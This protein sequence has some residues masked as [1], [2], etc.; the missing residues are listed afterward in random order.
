MEPDASPRE[1]KDL[2]DE[3][4]PPVAQEEHLNLPGAEGSLSEHE[5][6]QAFNSVQKVQNNEPPVNSSVFA[7]ALANK[8]Q[9]SESKGLQ[10]NAQTSSEPAVSI[11]RQESG[12][13]SDDES[14]SADDDG[15]APT[16]L[17]KPD[18][19]EVVSEEVA[20]YRNSNLS[21]ALRTK[22]IAQT[23]SLPMDKDCFLERY[24]SVL[25]EQ[26]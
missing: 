11:Q 22:I 21:H 4:L 20:E 18:E 13:T 17:L 1:S 3:P 26:E 19:L 2:N 24:R 8:K 23:D 10:A 6:A 12:V 25:T 7:I 14:Q 15:E 9:D 16:M 5:D